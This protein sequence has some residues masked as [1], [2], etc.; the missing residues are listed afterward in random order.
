MTAP[1]FPMTA[2]INTL[3]HSLASTR[4]EAGSFNQYG[5]DASHPD[6][7]E[8]NTIRRENLRLYL[9]QIA[10]LQPKT[11][12]VGEAAG[13]RGCRLTGVPFTSEAILLR[14]RPLV[15]GPLSPESNSFSFGSQ[16]GYRKTA[17]FD[18]IT[19]EATATMV[20]Q[21]LEKVWPP[22]LLW[23]AYPF[24]PHQ[25]GDLWSNRAPIKSELAI[26][27]HFITSI[28]KLFD[29][30]QV[31]AIG[32]K[33]AQSLKIS[34]IP[35]VEIRHPSHGGKRLFIDGLDRYLGSELDNAL[36]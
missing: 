3:I 21:A 36:A 2:S 30:K 14:S 5:Y 32:R 8:A 10:P 1:F 31:I 34:G 4:I 35:A 20:W 15:S 19:A 28:I 17:E 23:N 6:Q 22:A 16:M 7:A 18:R 12:L 25:P 13:Y 24:H 33:A 26:G 11:L 29:I 9:Q 27:D